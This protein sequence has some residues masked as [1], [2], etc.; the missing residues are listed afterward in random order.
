MNSEKSSKIITIILSVLF[1]FGATVG[2][3]AITSSSPVED[4]AEIAAP[5]PTPNDAVA[6]L[7]YNNANGLTDKEL[8]EI[9]TVL[10]ETG[11]SLM[12]NNFSFVEYTESV[13][14]PS[15]SIDEDDAKPEPSKDIESPSASP[16]PSQQKGFSMDDYAKLKPGT[17]S[18]AVVDLQQRLMDLNYLANDEP[19]NYYGTQT[20]YAIQLFQYRHELTANGVCNKATVTLLFSSNAKKYKVSIGMSGTDVTELQKRLKELGYLFSVTGYF[21]S[22]TDT[23]VRAFQK[24][25]GLSIDG[26]VGEQTREA[27]YSSG[28]IPASRPSSTVKPSPTKTQAPSASPSAKPTSKPV[29]PTNPPDTAKAQA[30]IAAAKTHLGA[31]YL[32]GG[33]GPDSFD[34]SGFIYY[35]LKYDMGCN[36]GY[37]T[38]AMWAAT[39]YPTISKNELQAGDILCFDGHVGIYLGN[40]AMIDASSTEGKVRIT[41]NIWSKNYWITHFKYGKR[42]FT[43]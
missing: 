33:K 16:I 38:S 20:A 26:Q 3:L 2:T 11:I 43:S 4:R 17:T 6:A 24:N 10:D 27:L 21:G 23:A 15:A 32:W 1:C 25:N 41:Y 29:T 35:V 8:A 34:C 14:S 19:T 5:T 22:D 39:S 18:A 40:G 12:P 37:H 7:S 28:A 42:Y 9:G 30:F 13:P 36:F 31:P